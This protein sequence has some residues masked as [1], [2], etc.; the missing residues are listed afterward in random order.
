[1][2]WGAS[3]LSA[4]A[5]DVMQNNVTRLEARDL[6]MGKIVAILYGS[7]DAERKQGGDENLKILVTENSIANTV[8]G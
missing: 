5:V 7:R 6:R 2:I 1:M 3:R 4:G 8:K